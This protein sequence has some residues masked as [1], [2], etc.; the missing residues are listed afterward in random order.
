VNKINFLFSEE[1]RINMPLQEGISEKVIS[2]N[3]K[4][5]I[6]AGKPKDQAIAIALD[7]AGKNSL[8]DYEKFNNELFKKTE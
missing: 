2:S 5:L 6:E 4:E 7:K 3:I 8:E 1:R